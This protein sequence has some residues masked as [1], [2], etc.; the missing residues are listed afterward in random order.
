MTTT[1]VTPTLVVVAA[2]RASLFVGEAHHLTLT[3]ITG[4]GLERPAPETGTLF[5]RSLMS[6]RRS[7][8]G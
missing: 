7:R 6:P 2:E 3:L 5:F 8:R 4:S 1:G